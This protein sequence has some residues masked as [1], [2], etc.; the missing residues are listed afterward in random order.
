MNGPVVLAA[1][2][3]RV[4]H[5]G[6]AGF[7]LFNTVSAVGALAGA[8]LAAR[9]RTHGPEGHRGRRRRLFGLAQLLR[10]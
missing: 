10:R 6:V 2:A 7:G 8:L 5:N 1:F 4:W 3:E 9:L